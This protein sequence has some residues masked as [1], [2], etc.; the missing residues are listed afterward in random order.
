VAAWVPDMFCN[1]Y[2]VKNH[3]ID[4]NLTTTEGREKIRAESESLQYKKVKKCKCLLVKQL[5]E[6]YTCRHN[7]KGLKSASGCHS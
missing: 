4:N 5:V 7:C 2:L 1:F 3:K 6:Q